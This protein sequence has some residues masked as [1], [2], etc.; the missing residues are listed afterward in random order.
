[1]QTNQETTPVAD[2]AAAAAINPLERRIDLSVALEHVDAA[3]DQRLK[4]MSRTVKMPGF[5]PGK[6]P[7]KLVT[8]Q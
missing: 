2:N 8:Q 4:R 1:M 3:T 6:V 7:M 5:R